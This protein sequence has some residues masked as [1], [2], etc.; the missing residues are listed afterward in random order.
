MA[1]ATV[2]NREESYHADQV[3]TGDAPAV[4][5]RRLKKREVDRRCQREARERRRSRIADLENLVVELRQKDASGQVAALLEQMR[6]VEQ[7][8]DTMAKALKDIQ[9]V[10]ALRLSKPG[11]DRAQGAGI[12][13]AQVAVEDANNKSQ[14]IGSTDTSEKLPWEMIDVTA[15]LLEEPEAVS[16]N[17]SEL[18]GSIATPDSGLAQSTSLVSPEVIQRRISHSIPHPG[19]QSWSA[20]RQ[21]SHRSPEIYEPISPPGSCCSVAHVDRQPGQRAVWQGNYWKYLSEVMGERFDWTQDIRPADDVESD[22]I[23][24]RA[25][26]EG[27]EAVERRGPLH[28]SWNMLRRIDEALFPRIAK[29]ERLAMLRAMH[30]LLQYHTDS[31]SARYKRLPPWYIYRPG[32]DVPHTYAIEYWAWPPFRQ[33]YI[34]NEHAYCGNDFWYMY[35]TQLRLLWPFDFRDCYTHDLETG[36]YKPSHLFNERLNDIKCWTMGPDFFQRYPELSSSIPISANHIPK[37]VPFAARPVRRRSVLPASA[38]SAKGA[39]SGCMAVVCSRERQGQRHEQG[40]EKDHEQETGRD[41]AAWPSFGVASDQTVP[42]H[43]VQ[44]QQQC[45]QTHNE[46][47]YLLSLPVHG[48]SFPQPSWE[49]S[50]SPA[51]PGWYNVADFDFDLSQMGSTDTSLSAFPFM[52]G[53][54]TGMEYH[55]GRIETGSIE[56]S[57]V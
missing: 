40:R 8:R 56:L 31:T 52:P 24:I 27:W 6:K 42:L 28:P 33:R 14:S 3:G 25:M 7:E 18:A 34:S 44:P 9:S 54:A 29:T 47:A 38:A 16:A 21:H 12:A 39:Q 32:H 15:P 45:G 22:D 49:P 51:F 37:H 2:K 1:T 26:V 23:P 50:C 20:N 36:L 13:A 19:T 11:E 46:Q 5:A 30:L 10:L 48:Y 17:F 55:P 53:A 57:E 41:Q 43:T 4:S 35:E